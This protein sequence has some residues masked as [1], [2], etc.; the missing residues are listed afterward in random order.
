MVAKHI[1]ILFNEERN[2]IEIVIEAPDWLKAKD[3]EKKRRGIIM[4]SARGK[5]KER[6]KP[7]LSI[8]NA[9]GKCNFLLF[10]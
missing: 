9:R 5:D 4:R 2:N 1:T 3:N 8:E 10:V 6:N 7:S